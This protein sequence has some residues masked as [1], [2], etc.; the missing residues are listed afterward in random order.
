VNTPDVSNVYGALA[1]VAAITT[2]L[3]AAVALQPLTQ[4]VDISNR[5]R[6]SRPGSSGRS[7]TIADAKRAKRSA[8]VLNGPAVIV[9]A[10]VL[11]GWGKIAIGQT[12]TD[13][14]ELY[15]P[16]VA[17]SCAAVF[18]AICAFWAVR[19]LRSMSKE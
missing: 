8:L 17:V 12:T 6:A 5:R 19:E 3:Q 18:L 16:W 15:V 4:A 2:A 1:N 13:N 7:D 14:W 11:A 10:A 9:N